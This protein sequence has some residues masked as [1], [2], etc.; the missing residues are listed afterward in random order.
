LRLTAVN[1][2][3]TH[4]LVSISFFFFFSL[5]LSLSLS[6]SSSHRNRSLLSP[7]ILVLIIIVYLCDYVQPIDNAL[8]FLIDSIILYKY[9]GILR[10][11]ILSTVVRV[12]VAIMTIELVAKNDLAGGNSYSSSNNNNCNNN[13][14]IIIMI[15]IIIIIVT[16]WY[17]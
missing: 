1:K 11:Y 15:I 12:M 14:V 13:I 8:F 10:D 6:L 17:S 2:E 9:V 4:D 16:S 5:S 7:A 3:A